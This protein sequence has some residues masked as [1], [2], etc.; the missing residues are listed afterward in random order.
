MTTK[1]C[2][3]EIIEHK[4]S[5]RRQVENDVFNS[6]IIYQK[7]I[8]I[9]CVDILKSENTYIKNSKNHEILRRTENIY[10]SE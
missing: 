5:V 6:L 8:F 2:M 1:I 7:Y 10:K 4:T 3:V 9:I